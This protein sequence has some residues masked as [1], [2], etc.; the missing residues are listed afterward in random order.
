G[1]TLGGPFDHD[2]TFFFFAF[3]QRRRQETGFF[4]SNVRAG[5]NGSATIGAPF[6]PFTQTYGNITPAQAA[7]VNG[8]LTTAGQLIGAG[9]VAQGQ[10]LATAAITYATFASSGGY[11]ALAGTNS[12]IRRGRGLRPHVVQ[13]LGR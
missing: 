8:L 11:T 5:L 12:I 10:A 2:R 1:A 6:L 9:Q 4:T 7:Y 3:E 13:V